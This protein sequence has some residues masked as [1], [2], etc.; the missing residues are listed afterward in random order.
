LPGP[1][2]GSPPAVAPAALPVTPAGPALP[3]PSLIPAQNVPA[4]PPPEPTIDQLI[5]RL[6][7]LRQQKQELDRQ[8]RAVTEQVREALRKQ[9]E[10]L[11]RLGVEEAT[12]P[13]PSVPSSLHVDPP[14]APAPGVGRG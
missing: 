14:A 1:A 6:E 4:S 10:R 7:R 9:R 2:V 3:P 11:G 5:D 8:E 12:P 13:P